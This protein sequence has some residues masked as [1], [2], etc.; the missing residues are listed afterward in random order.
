MAA[1]GLPAQNNLTGSLPIGPFDIVLA[2]PPWRFASNSVAKPGRNALRHYDCMTVRDIGL[3]PVRDIVA[4]DALLLMWVTV[5]FAR[6]AFDVVDAWG[7]TYKSQIV[8]T[9]SRI[10]TGYWARNRHEMLYV[11]RRGAFPCLRPALFPDSIIP[12]AQREHSRKPDWIHQIIDAR[13]PAARRIELFS[14]Q[15]RPGWTVWGYETQ[16]FLIEEAIP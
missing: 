4:K 12:G 16:K 14:R 8:W 7:F 5:P 15:Q 6:Q 10:G 3:M 9:K 11:C 2:D 1:L 13:F